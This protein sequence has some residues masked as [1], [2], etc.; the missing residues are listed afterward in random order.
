M[1]LVELPG[2]LRCRLGIADHE[3]E[4][5]NFHP[6]EAPRR[7][8]GQG[9]D[10]VGDAVARL[11]EELRGGAAQLH[12]RIEL[13]LQASR[14]LLLDPLAPRHEHLRVRRGAG[15]QEVMDLE[16]DRRLRLRQRAAGQRERKEHERA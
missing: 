14:R 2:R 11:V 8:A 1:L 4:L 5:E 10:D 7:V 9:P 15:R 3:R 6:R 16:S 13:A 12:R